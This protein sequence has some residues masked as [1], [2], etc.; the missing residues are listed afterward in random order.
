MDK[1]TFEKKFKKINYEEIAFNYQQL[2]EVVHYFYGPYVNPRAGLRIIDLMNMMN[3]TR[4]VAEKKLQEALDIMSIRRLKPD[5]CILIRDF[6]LVMEIDY[7]LIQLFLLSFRY[8]QKD[9][10]KLNTAAVF[11]RR[12]RPTKFPMQ[13]VR[14][15]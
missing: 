2:M 10:E 14:N 9:P 11:K 12:R 5:E 6:C 3:C 15:T 1:L 4:S 13:I 8:K 7:M